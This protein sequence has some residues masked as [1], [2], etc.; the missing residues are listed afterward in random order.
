MASLNKVMFIG[1]L[2]KNLEDPRTFANGG[3][4]LEIPFVTDGKKKRDPQ[5]NELVDDPLFIDMKLFSRGEDRRQIDLALGS[6]RKGSQIYVEGRL[7]QER[8]ETNDGQKRS[9]H[10]VYVGNFQF[11]DPKTEGGQRDSYSGSRSSSSSPDDNFGD[12]SDNFENES[13]SADDPSIPF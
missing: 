3:T 7:I 8:W 10:V 13:T 4:V 5:T 12:F 6:L 9:K 11:L 1:R 2:W